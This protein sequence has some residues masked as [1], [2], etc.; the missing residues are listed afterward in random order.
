MAK[1]LRG[2]RDRQTRGRLHGFIN[3]EQSVILLPNPAPCSHHANP[4]EGGDPG[5]RPDLQCVLFS[6]FILLPVS[7]RVS[8]VAVSISE[9]RSANALRNLGWMR[10]P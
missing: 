7:F 6:L 3:R 8:A 9:Y 10:V 4:S 2:S 1:R 5:A